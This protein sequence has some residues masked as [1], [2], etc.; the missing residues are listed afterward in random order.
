LSVLLT[1]EPLRWKSLVLLSPHGLRRF[2]LLVELKNLQSEHIK[3]KTPQ[4]QQ[5]LEML[6]LLLHDSWHL[7]FMSFI[8]A[9]AGNFET[10]VSCAMHLR[11][12]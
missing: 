12:C 9:H 2:R 3:N 7:S 1:A 8:A 10:P 11:E 4:L 5:M 6:H